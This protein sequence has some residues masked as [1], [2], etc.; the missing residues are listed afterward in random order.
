MNLIKW[1]DDRLDAWAAQYDRLDN[2]VDMMDTALRDAAHEI[3]DIQAAQKL[4]NSIRMWRLMFFA[5]ML[6]PVA[7]I[8]AVFIAVR[9][10]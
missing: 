5:T 7:T 3:E 10:R 8:I 6:S 1:N 9:G 2:K 4:L